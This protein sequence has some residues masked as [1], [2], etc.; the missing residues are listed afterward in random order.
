MEPKDSPRHPLY[1]CPARH[2]PRHTEAWKDDGASMPSV[3]GPPCRYCGLRAG[4]DSFREATG[5]MTLHIQSGI[6]QRSIPEKAGAYSVEA[7]VPGKL[8][9]PQ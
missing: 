8:V 7:Y 3:R 9:G 5:E 1:V 4:C 2:V 6:A